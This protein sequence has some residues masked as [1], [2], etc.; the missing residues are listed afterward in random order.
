MRTR[1]GMFRTEKKKTVAR[2]VKME[3]R[4]ICPNCGAQDATATDDGVICFDCGFFPCEEIEIWG[5]QL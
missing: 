1:K 2:G 3:G 4:A 5:E